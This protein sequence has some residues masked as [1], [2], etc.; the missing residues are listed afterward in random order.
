MDVPQS[1]TE[2]LRLKRRLEDGRLNQNGTNQ[3]KVQLLLE[4]GTAYPLEGTLAVPRRHGGSDHRV[5]HPAGCLSQSE[6]RSPAGHVRPGGGEGRRQ[7]AG[8]PDSPAGGVARS[9]GKSRRA[10]RGRRGQGRTADAHARPRHRRPMARLLGSCTR[11]PGDR[12]G[13]AE[14]AARRCRERGS[15]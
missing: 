8:H 13:H 3:N 2:L 6:G 5:R 10:D 14:S 15:L 9:Q 12:R 7:R 11:R 4:D 1:T